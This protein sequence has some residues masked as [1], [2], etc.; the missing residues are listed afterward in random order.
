MFFS[1]LPV[2]FYCA[3]AFLVQNRKYKGRKSIQN[4]SSSFYF[5]SSPGCPRFRFPSDNYLPFQGLANPEPGVRAARSKCR[6][7]HGTWTSSVTLRPMSSAGP[8]GT[9]SESGE[10]DFHYCFLSLNI[11]PY[12]QLICDEQHVRLFYAI[13]FHLCNAHISVAHT[14]NLGHCSETTEARFQHT[15]I[16][17][18]FYDLMYQHCTGETSC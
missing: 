14:L 17:P 18:A 6:P 3:S 11:S 12:A 13:I 2:P 15:I 9:W 16:S 10:V 7:G 4:S 8:L 5:C 1:T